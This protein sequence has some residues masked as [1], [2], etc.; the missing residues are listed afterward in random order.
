MLVD[1]TRPAL[2]IRP[3][4]FLVKVCL[5]VAFSLSALF[6][7]KDTVE[8]RSAL[9]PSIFAFHRFIL[10]VR[11]PSETRGNRL[12]IERSPTSYLVTFL[13]RRSNIPE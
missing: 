4:S 6:K 13:G 10:S 2:F 11:S 9:P 12:S 1:V 5:P 3:V 7:F 8:H